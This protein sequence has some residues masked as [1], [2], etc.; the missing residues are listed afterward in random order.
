V[1]AHPTALYRLLRLLGEF[2]VFAELEGR[3]F[4]L[5]PLSELLRGD[6]EGS[7]RG[8]A[9][10]VETPWRREAWG[11]LLEAV[12]TGRPAFELAHGKPF[13]DYLREH[14][15][16]AAVFDLAMTGISRQVIASIVDAYDFGRFET[17]VDVGGGNGA[18][19]AAILADNPGVRGVLY[20]L[21]DV[22]ARARVLIAEAGVADRCDVLTATSSSTSPRAPTHIS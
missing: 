13:F 20:E 7:M 9:M 15:D 2:G 5:T 11:H 4:G 22:A 21:R 1:G 12:R 17:V 8:W 16:E 18:P 6:A 14:P 10:M 19:L 3:R